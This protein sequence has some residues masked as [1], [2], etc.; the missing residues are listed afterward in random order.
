MAERWP[1]VPLGDLLQPVSRPEQV[2]AGKPYRVLGAHWYAGGLYIK[3]T[4][5][6]AQI[7]ANKV[8]RVETGDFVYNRL[9]AWKGA[10]AVAHPATHGCY[11]SNEFPCFR[12]FADRLDPQYLRRYMSREPAWLEAL[13]LSTGGTPTSRN[14]L[15][16]ERLLGMRIP[17]PPISEQRQIVARINALAEKTA[18]GRLLQI[19]AAEAHRAILPSAINYV[20]NR[21]GSWPTD[22]IG[23]LAQT[24]SGQVDPQSDPYADM[25]H[26]NGESIEAGTCRLLDR[27]RTAREDG[28]TSGK[29][30]FPPGA[31]LYSKIRPYLMKAARI[32]FEGVCSADVYAFHIFSPSIDPNF[33][34]YSLIAAPFTAYA[35]RLSGRT[36]MPKLNQSQMFNFDM[37]YPCLAEQ[38][39]IVAYLDAVADRAV[40][41]QNLHDAATA[42]L[43]ALLPSILD[44]AFRGELLPEIGSTKTNIS[45]KVVAKK[46]VA[47]SSPG[48]APAAKKPTPFKDDAAVLCVLTEELLKRHRPTDEFCLQKHTYMGHEHWKLPINSTFKREAAGPWSQQLTHKAI[49]AA[50]QQNWLRWHN[51]QLV[52]GRLFQRGLAHAA[53]LS[54]DVRSKVKEIVTDLSNFGDHGLERWATVLMAARD[55][56]AANKPISHAAIQQEMD[57][58]P[59]KRAKEIFTEESVEKTIDAMARHGWLKNLQ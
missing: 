51:G 4:L 53:T 46:P 11:V 45:A 49:Y 32:P 14:R 56:Q 19:S 41:L 43:N 58:W 47:I 35:N 39:Q 13:G 26:I 12:V 30:H 28:V 3:D 7:R 36:R 15:K 57:Q 38:C 21:S 20:W 27:Y 50:T 54:D 5:D 9:F 6:G 8:Y 10:F 37:A 42:E 34:A 29:F 40:A 52:P 23:N 31:V 59:G 24:V 25:P 48:T 1:T 16:Q 44:R 22:K 17:L 2:E 33:F 55:L 18:E